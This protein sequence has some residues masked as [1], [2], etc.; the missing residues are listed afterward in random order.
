MAGPACGTETEIKKTDRGGGWPMKMLARWVVVSGLVLGAGAVQAATVNWVG[1]SGDWD[2]AADWSTSALPA[3]GD[4]VYITNSG[5]IVTYIN[6]SNNP[7]LNSLTIDATGTGA[8]LDQGQDNLSADSEKIGNSGIGT[9]AQSGGTN[10]VSQ[11]LA[12]GWL[13]GSSGTYTL[14]GTGS[15]SAGWEYIGNSGTGTFTQTGGTN[16]TTG[17]G[18]LFLGASSG[19]TGS[20]TLSGGTLTVG[21]NIVGGSGTS[22]FTIDGGTLNVGGGNGSINVGTFTVGDSGGAGNYALSGGSLTVS[23]EYVGNSGTGT[24]TQSG[25]T[26]T[27]GNLYLGFDYGGSGNYA[28]SGTGS[29]SASYEYVGDS[30]TGTFTQSGGTNTVSENLFLGENGSGTYALSGTGSLSAG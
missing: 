20:Y 23:T 17:T 30:G 5:A 16:T 22:S 24:F 6:P 29:L 3:A 14:S 1:S 27:T 8:T 4:D 7:L 19:G 21:G 10:T 2:T 28:L 25:G 11:G 15:L 26:D 18:N 13:S 9:F 12:L